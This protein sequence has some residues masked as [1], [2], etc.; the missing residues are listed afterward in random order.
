MPLRFCSRQIL[1]L[2]ALLSCGVLGSTRSSC[3]AR[4]AMKQRSKENPPLLEKH[5]E[6]EAG[7]RRMSRRPTLLNAL[8]HANRAVALDNA[9][10]VSEAT[11]EYNRTIELLEGVLRGIGEGSSDNEDSVRIKKI[12]DS[13]RN[14]THLLISVCESRRSQ[15]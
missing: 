5:N 14:R 15:E 8:D 11:E 4:R 7:T 6:T 2:L 1:Q 13:Y 3:S 12:C 10:S 9:G